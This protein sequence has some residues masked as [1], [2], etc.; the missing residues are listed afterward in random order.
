MRPFSEIAH[1]A[2]GLILMVN[3]LFLFFGQLY[4]CLR[5][6]RLRLLGYG[7]IFPLV[8]L[9][10]GFALFTI[11]LDCM[12]T[13][14]I[15]GVPRTS[16]PEIVLFA[17]RIPWL[18]YLGIELLSGALLFVSMGLFRHH[19]RFHLMPISV[20]AAVDFLPTGIAFGDNS[21][22]VLSNQC[23][24]TL[25]RE[26]TGESLFDI[27]RFRAALEAMCEDR[28][29]RLLARTP[30]GSVWLFDRASVTLDGVEY[31]QLTASDVTELVHGTDDLAAKNKRLRD[32][33][34]RMNAFRFRE[35]DMFISRE[36]MTARAIVHNHMGNILLLGKYYLDH[37]ES[38]DES[39]LL[40][41]MRAANRFLVG[42]VETPDDITDPYDY[43]MKMAKSIGVTVNL[44]GTV[45]E[46]PSARELLSQVI[47]ECS[48]N[49]YKHAESDAINVVIEPLAGRTRITVS[50]NGQTPKT[51]IRESGGL[52]SLR[53]MAEDI[54]GTM[55]TEYEPTFRL[56]LEYPDA[57]VGADSK[58]DSYTAVG[59]DDNP[60]VGADGDSMGDAGTK[61]VQ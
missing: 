31:E 38:T 29:G 19:L 45:P 61:P 1:S 53:L 34:V 24:N 47:E 9:F 33:A 17:G 6:V 27:H 40:N 23:I 7:I 15:N 49:A 43:A 36:I 4:T 32:V 42:E 3:A 52:R 56:I 22:I 13:G 10:S 8:H 57:V 30:G 54:G 14:P 12:Y 50:N 41:T 20:K 26:L 16:Y 18:V 25:A 37:P 59:A 2:G 44:Q 11:A 46:N 60:A 28:D 55:T 58:D 51:P 21:G 5:S 39:E 35:T 48:A